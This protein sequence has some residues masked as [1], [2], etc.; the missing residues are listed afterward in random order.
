[1]RELLMN[2]KNI[3]LFLFSPSKFIQMAINN[4][5]HEKST[6]H[7]EL[8]ES[9]RQSMQN[10]TRIMRSSLFG[11]IQTLIIMI[12]LAYIISL[13]FKAA[14]LEIL[15]FFII[16]LRFLS[17]CFIFI[18]IWGKAG[19]DIETWD[20]T[21]LPEQVNSHLSKYLY[22]TGMWIMLVSYLI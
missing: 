9:T 5:V 21:T 19:W 6:V 13:I 17:G 12:L 14:S 8:E 16:V 18:G 10:S 2:L 3:G 11:A 4:N 7:Q 22:I 15:S 20:G 1:M